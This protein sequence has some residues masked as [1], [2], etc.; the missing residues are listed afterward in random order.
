MVSPSKSNSRTSPSSS[1]Q[2]GQATISSF[3]PPSVSSTSKHFPTRSDL[4]KRTTTGTIVDL[5]GDDSAEEQRAPKRK[6][7]NGVSQKNEASFIPDLS[8]P[9]HDGFI[10]PARKNGVTQSSLQSPKTPNKSLSKYSFT[11]AP[12]IYEMPDTPEEKRAKKAR[13]ETFKRKLLAENNIFGRRSEIAAPTRRPRVN[14][15]VIDIDDLE[16]I[17]ERVADESE[18]EGNDQETCALPASIKSKAFPSSKG[19]G[20]ENIQKPFAK[21]SKKPVEEIGPSGQTYTPLEKQVNLENAPFMK[22]A[23]LTCLPVTLGTSN[24]TSASVE[25]SIPNTNKI[26]SEVLNIAHFPD[27]NF[28]AASVPDHRR[29]IH[30]RREASSKAQAR[31]RVRLE[32]YKEELDYTDSFKELQTFYSRTSNTASE[33]FKS[34]KLLA[35]VSDLP[36]KIVVALAHSL[37][38]LNSFGLGDVLTQTQFFSKFTERQHMLLN[39]NTLSNLFAPVSYRASS[40]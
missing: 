4:G 23:F 38:Y 12:D 22:G 32:W 33:N 5:T 17:K 21:P 3:F 19:K 25:T 10:S 27:R 7:L 31:D 2:R 18:L 35:A 8:N 13:R 29:D 1:P 30:L 14:D 6:K 34:G 20:R 37:N 26:A 39:A 16:N 15:D 36:R 40:S 28:L 9:L 11:Q 24:H